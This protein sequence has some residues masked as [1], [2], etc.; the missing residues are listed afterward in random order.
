M[1]LNWNDPIGRRVDIKISIGSSIL[2][3]F[4]VATSSLVV[5]Q[6]P[7]NENVTIGVSTLNCVAESEEVNISFIISNYKPCTVT[8]L[9]YMHDYISKCKTPSTVVQVLVIS[10]SLSLCL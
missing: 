4:S 6:I 2:Q 1:T 3:Q 7:Y 8:G 9:S 5:D 10:L